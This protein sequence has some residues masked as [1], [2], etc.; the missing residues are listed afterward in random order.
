ML[1]AKFKT[2][3]TG[4]IPRLVG[5]FAWHKCQSVCFFFSAARLLFRL[6]LDSFYL[7]S[8]VKISHEISSVINKTHQTV[9][10]YN[11]FCFCFCL[12]TVQ[13]FSA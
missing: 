13:G 9:D 4:S 5:V 1:T 11:F 3:L 12:N 8:Q 2:D 6:H 7:V 10:L